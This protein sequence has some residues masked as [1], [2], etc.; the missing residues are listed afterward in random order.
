VLKEAIFQ[1]IQYVLWSVEGVFCGM[2]GG[3]FVGGVGCINFG[4]SCRH[5]EL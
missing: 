3:W 5:F 4:I 1:E 2:R